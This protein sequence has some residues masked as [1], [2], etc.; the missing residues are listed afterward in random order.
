MEQK[1]AKDAKKDRE[2]ASE[3]ECGTERDEICLWKMPASLAR[4]LEPANDNFLRV[5]FTQG[6]GTPALRDTGLATGL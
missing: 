6:G 5:F 1:I 4:A 2:T 3:W